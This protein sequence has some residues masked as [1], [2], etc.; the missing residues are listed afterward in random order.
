MDFWPF[1]NSTHVNL[2]WIIGKKICQ[3]ER[4]N[5][6]FQVAKIC[7]STTKLLL[8]IAR[9]DILY[10]LRGSRWWILHKNLGHEHR[11]ARLA[12]FFSGRLTKEELLE[13][14]PPAGRQKGANKL[15]H[16]RKEQ[17][18]AIKIVFLVLCENLFKHFPSLPNKN[19]LCLAILQWIAVRRIRESTSKRHSHGF[20]GRREHG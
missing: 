9:R 8:T 20:W 4:V 17:E 12:E 19:L 15:I 3:A 5:I 11:K 6:H 7:I 16:V 1:I 2:K 10:K 13:L 18:V 14:C